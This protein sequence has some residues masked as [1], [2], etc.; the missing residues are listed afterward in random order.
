MMP[1]TQHLR[2]LERRIRSLVNDGVPED[3]IASRFRRSPAFIRQVI[4]LSELPNRAAVAMPGGLRPI[5][6]R[7]LRWRDQGAD[8]NELSRRFRRRPESVEQVEHLA[9]YKL[10]R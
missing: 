10:S 8:L 6:R 4:E 9:R 1:N 7:V 5:E 3:E 2:P